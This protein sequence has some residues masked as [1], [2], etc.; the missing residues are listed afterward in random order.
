MAPERQL[1]RTSAHIPPSLPM[2]SA[3]LADFLSFLNC[4]ERGY[5]AREKVGGVL[6]YVLIGTQEPR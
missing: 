3:G 5:G 4:Q 6:W 2:V 1:A